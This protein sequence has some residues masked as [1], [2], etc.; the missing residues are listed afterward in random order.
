MRI[1]ELMLNCYEWKGL[2]DSVDARYLELLLIQ[3][4]NALFYKDPDGV[5]DYVALQCGMSGSLNIYDEPQTRHGIANNGYNSP[6]LNE[7]N[8]VI[9]WNNFMRS[10]DLL[11]IDIFA[12]RL[13]TIDRTI[14]VNVNA[15]KTPI[16]VK[17]SESQRLTMENVYR[18][19]NGDCP[20]IFGDKDSDLAAC[21]TVLKTDAPY[22]AD[23]MQI[24]K[25]QIWNEI[26]TYIGIDNS[27][28][29]KAERMVTDEIT[30]NLGAVVAQRY[31]RIN[32]RRQAAEK[33]NKM[34]GLNVTIDFRDDLLD[35]EPKEEVKEETTNE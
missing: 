28:T 14:D 17:T 11:A 23:K 24:L 12:E 9:I 20:V 5:L 35:T 21:F 16:L 13:A 15:Q 6:M 18:D 29:E 8:S 10:N 4:G 19:Y 22:V 2:P 27:N 3:Y 34:Y 25:R 26:L 31:V 7:S 32:A 30:S 33:I 1:K